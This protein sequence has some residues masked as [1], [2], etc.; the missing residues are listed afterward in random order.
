MDV[1]G[2]S[3]RLND[4]NLKANLLLEG[5]L[6]IPPIL[7]FRVLISRWSA[8]THFFITSCKELS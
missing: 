8:K 6:P 5:L 4:A 7:Q 1:A 3:K 2:V